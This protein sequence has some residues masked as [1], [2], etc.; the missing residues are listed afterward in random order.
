S[1]STEP[2]V[3]SAISR[4]SADGPNVRLLHDVGNVGVVADHGDVI[5]DGSNLD[6][7]GRMLL[8]CREKH[9]QDFATVQ[10]SAR[11]PPV[12]ELGIVPE[13][14]SDLVAPLSPDGGYHVQPYIIGEH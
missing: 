1:V 12:A 7:S 4:N 6:V 11:Q 8:G 13:I 10:P 2:A 3:A 9:E 14:D 5:P